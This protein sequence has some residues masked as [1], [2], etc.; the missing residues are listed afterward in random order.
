MLNSPTI[1]I[2]TPTYNR[3]H[4]LP[5]ML[6]SIINQNYAN[7]ELVIADDGSKDNT[8]EVVLNYKDSRIRYFKS[9]NRGATVQRNFGVS[10]ATGDY[11]IFLDSDDWVEKDWLEKLTSNLIPEN[12]NVIVTC[13]WRKVNQNFN[14][15][16]KGYP[17]NLGPMFNNLK[18]NFLSGTLLY[19]KKY[20]IEIGG[21]DEELP[22]G[23]HTEILIRLLYLIKKYKT[24]IKIIEHP[25]VNI[26]IHS[27]LRIRHNF[28]GIY[29][30]S[31]LI[32]NKHLGLFEK[33]P[34]KHFDY[35]SIIAVCAYRTGRT[36]ESRKYS[37]KA[38]TI[39]PFYYLSYVRYLIANTPLLGNK[40][41]GKKR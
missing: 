39:K 25:L 16:E 26:Y 5:R 27:G 4:L 2:I 8:E 37:K 6:D 20:F 1:S 22:S 19:P 29:Q 34:D 10:K 15:I 7:W 35:L 24:Q 3:A 31:K 18:L 33:H 9:D 21:Y 23:H 38:I 13:G 36:E 30:G 41:W 40:V 11:I 17:E 28:D 32:L 12:N 14:E